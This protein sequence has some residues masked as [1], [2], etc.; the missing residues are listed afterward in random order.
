MKCKMWRQRRL[1][2]NVSEPEHPVGQKTFTWAA[3]F[4]KIVCETKVALLLSQD[5]ETPK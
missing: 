5:G 3:Q 4:E 2:G 1:E